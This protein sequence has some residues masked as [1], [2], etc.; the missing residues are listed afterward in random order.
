MQRG[1]EGGADAVEAVVGHRRGEDLEAGRQGG[2]SSFSPS[3]NAVVGAVGL[4][5]TSTRPKA[6]SKSR[7]ISVRTRWAV[8]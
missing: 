3:L 6:A 1:L 7:E 4:T 5:S 8:P 2:S